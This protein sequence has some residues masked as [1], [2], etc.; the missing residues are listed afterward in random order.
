MS[1]LTSL[2]FKIKRR[3]WLNVVARLRNRS[4]YH[5]IYVAR[6][7]AV[8][9]QRNTG[10]AHKSYLSAVPNPGAGIGHQMANWIAGLW[11]SKYFGMQFA[12]IP[13]SSELWENLLG[14]GQ[15]LPLVSNLVNKQQYK[16]VQLPLFD[17]SSESEVQLIQKLIASYGDQKIVFILEQDQFYRDQF[18]VMQELKNRFFNSPSRLN[19]KFLFCDELL[20][21]AIHVRRG[22][23]VDGQ[24]TG[25]KNLTLRWQ[26]TS[27]FTNVLRSVLSNIQANKQPKVYVFSQGVLGDLSEFDQFGN[28][29]Y[30]FEMSPQDSFLHMVYADI[31]ITSKSSFSY[32]PALLCN[33]L[34]VCPRNFWHGYPDDP[35]WVL[36]DEDGS[37]DDKALAQLASAYAS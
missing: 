32:K 33:G 29:Q 18:G 30:C 7:H 17:E 14:L 1:T 16:K 5:W 37:F 10:N 13:F 15:T 6:W 34:K 21:I 25:N 11:F 27:Y 23:I 35:L 24:R 8:I 31:L 36:A 28:V 22:D 9:F 4:I 12:H 19:D 26:D 3:I 20:N 2:I